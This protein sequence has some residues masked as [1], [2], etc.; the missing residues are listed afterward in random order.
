V[1]VRLW[2]TRVG[3]GEAVRGV[4][5]DASIQVSEESPLPIM[6]KKQ[7]ITLPRTLV[8]EFRGITS[9]A[10]KFVKA[11]YRDNE[12]NGVVD[13]DTALAFAEAMELGLEDI[14]D[15]LYDLGSNSPDCLDKLY[16]ELAELIDEED[17]DV[18]V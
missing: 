7:D 15:S 14:R 1:V 4:V 3:Q 9:L 8:Q 10:K 13:P 18:E 2:T 6:T 11:A 12:E 16:E 17:E 5:M